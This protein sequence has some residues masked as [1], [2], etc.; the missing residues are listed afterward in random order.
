VDYEGKTGWFEKIN[1]K[2]QSKLE[3]YV[4]SKSRIEVS[5]VNGAIDVAGIEGGSSIESINGSI[6]AKK[7][8]QKISLETINGNITTVN[9]EGKVNIETINGSVIDSQSRGELSASSVQGNITSNSRYNNVEI[10][11]VN[12]DVNLNLDKI[13]ELSIDSVNGKV[14]ASMLL[15]KKGD[16]SVSNVNGSVTL[17]FNK[18]VS[19]EFQIDAFVGGK[20][21]NELTD[22]KE[23]NLRNRDLM[24]PG[25]DIGGNGPDNSPI[26]VFPLLNDDQ[27]KSNGLPTLTSTGVLHFNNSQIRLDG[28]RILNMGFK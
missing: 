21:I 12:G 19:A 4:P 27:Y 25:I 20:I 22:D 1:V 8:K 11:I 15:N 7:L 2:D 16:V 13:D 23:N 24:I 9:M 6:V 10:E 26:A 3:F 28:K 5:T 17:Q 18:D 14:L